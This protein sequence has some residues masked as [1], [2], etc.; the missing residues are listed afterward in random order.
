MTPVKNAKQPTKHQMKSEATRVALLKA[1]ETVFARD[2]YERAQIDQIAK[3]SGRTRGAVYA[4]FKTKEQLFFALQEERI[5]SSSRRLME[6]LARSANTPEERL[7][8]LRV[9]HAD[10]HESDT[11]I[12]DLELKLY[13]IRNPNAIKKWRNRYS[14]L[15]P[16]DTFSE[17]FGVS[18]K[19]GRAS[20][21]SR[22]LALAAVKS[23]LI[24]AAHFFRDQLTAKEVT[25]LLGE[26]FDGLFPQANSIFASQK[27]R[28]TV[29]AKKPRKQIKKV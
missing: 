11:A 6:T 29:P 5:R 13:C 20:I 24:L 15:F 18:E 2:G 19:P 27:K 1:A 4:Q 21:R 3:E 9:Y 25:L 10:L 12:L 22:V 17:C 8:G 26:T 23:S 14:Q 7:A 28:L 16:T